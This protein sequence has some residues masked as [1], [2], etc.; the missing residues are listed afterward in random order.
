MF[1]EA[2]DVN[3]TEETMIIFGFQDDLDKLKSQRYR[4]A[5]QGTF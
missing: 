4:Q 1:I 5:I 3:T 2:I